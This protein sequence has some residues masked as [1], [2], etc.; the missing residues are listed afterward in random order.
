[1]RLVLEFRWNLWHIFQGVDLNG[2]PQLFKKCLK[3][4]K[5]IRRNLSTYPVNPSDP[6]SFKK[7]SFELSKQ[8][9]ELADLPE[10]CIGLGTTIQQPLKPCPDKELGKFNKLISKLMMPTTVPNYTLAWFKSL[11]LWYSW[12]N[13]NVSVSPSVSE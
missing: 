8:S 5:W 1:M 2:W 3:F 11:F 12:N 13:F 10:F 9:G 4:K 7:N 6:A